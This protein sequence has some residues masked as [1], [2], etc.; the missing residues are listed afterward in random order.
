MDDLHSVA[1]EILIRHKIAVEHVEVIGAGEQSICYGTQDY[2]LLIGADALIADV[3]TPN[4]YPLQQWMTAQAVRANART[5]W[6][7]AIGNQ[8]R[9]YALMRRAKGIL[10]SSTASQASDAERARW[11]CRMGAE[12]RKINAIPL[13]GFGELIPTGDGT[14]CGRYATWADYLDACI[15]RYLTPAS[16]NGHVRNACD[17]LLVHGIL[18]SPDMAQIADRL[19]VAKGWETQSVLVHY[20]NRLSNLMVEGDEVTLLDWGLAYAGIGLPQ[21]LIKVTEAPPAS[22]EHDPVRAFLKG[23]GLAEAEWDETIE[24]SRLMLVLDGLAMA[25]AWIET[26]DPVYLNGVHQWLRS[27]KRLCTET[28]S[29]QRQN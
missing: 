7:E 18:S 14:Y 13:E 10:A 5:I 16:A 25:S 11:F 23:Y 20:D 19:H 1:I 2:A 28:V 4:S 9:P 17:R 24:R 27:I 21:E 12:V 15:A 6:I 22:V 26:D 3:R 8:P 29:I